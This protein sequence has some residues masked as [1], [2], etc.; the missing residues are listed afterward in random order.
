MKKNLTNKQKKEQV[1][2]W[3]WKI[4]PSVFQGNGKNLCPLTLAPKHHHTHIPARKMRNK[5]G[6][7]STS[8]L[9]QPLKE[10]VRAMFPDFCLCVSVATH[11]AKE[12]PKNDLLAKLISG[13]RDLGFLLERRKETGQWE[14]IQQSVLQ[15]LFVCFAFS[16]AIMYTEFK[17]R[18]TKVTY[19]QAG[20]LNARGRLR[21]R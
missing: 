5:D 13:L 4:S 2:L 14:G 18:V 20:V 10:P 12:A 15:A 9:S 16:E 21:S 3:P 6:K 8:Q 7:W 19:P 1:G 17:V 11:I